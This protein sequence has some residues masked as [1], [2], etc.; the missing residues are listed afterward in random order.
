MELRLVSP[1]LE[2][3]R[4]LYLFDVVFGYI[5]KYFTIYFY[6]FA[7]ICYGESISHFPTNSQSGFSYLFII[8]EC[9]PE[10]C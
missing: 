8:S 5:W 7:T 6:S 1:L 9:V 3:A 10:F 2:E 4:M